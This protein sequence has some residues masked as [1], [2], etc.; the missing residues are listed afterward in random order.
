M[1][2]LPQLSV[3]VAVPGLTV[4]VHWPAAVLVVRAAGV[5]RVGFSLS[6]TVTVWV[7]VVW[8]PA[9]SVAVQVTV[10]VPRG[11]SPGASLVTLLPAQLSLVVGVPSTTPLAVHWPG[12]ALTVT[13][14]GAVREGFSP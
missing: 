1:L 3:A 2:A 8:L 5:V 4:A 7:A 14:P 12:S 13:G 11:K 9:A 10:V 6:F